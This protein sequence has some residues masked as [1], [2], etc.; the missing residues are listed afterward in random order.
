MAHLPQHYLGYGYEPAAQT[1]PLATYGSY[2][3]LGQ[4]AP[5]PP[6]ATGFSLAN[7][8]VRRIV[9][10]VVIVIVVALVLRE[11]MKLTKQTKKLERNEVVARLSTKELA[12]RLYERLEKK[13][14]ANPQVMR[15]LERY[16]R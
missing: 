11:L 7:L 6:V 4:L 12:Q 9:M 15:S 13:G 16:A 10:G 2:S 5:A 1:Y 14:R 8:D 3:G